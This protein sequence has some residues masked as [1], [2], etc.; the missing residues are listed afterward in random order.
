[1]KTKYLIIQP[2]SLDALF[3]ASH[4]LFNSDKYEVAVLTVEGDNKRLKEDSVLSE[5]LDIPFLDLDFEFIDNSYQSYW[6]T[7]KEVTPELALEFLY[8]FF[9]KDTMNELENLLTTAIQ[10]FQK[11]NKG[12]IV[13]SPWGCGEAFHMFVR[14]VIEN[15]V[16]YVEY[17]REFPHSYKKRIQNQ[18]EEQK[19]Q[20][21]FVR[22]VDTDEFHDLKFEVAKRVYKTQGGTLWFEQDYI[23][24]RLD[25]EIY[26]NTI[27]PF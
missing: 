10:K 21:N 11:K 5:M 17:Y 27:I 1:M 2:H 8:D 22:T 16:S 14:L 23:R 26:S 24:K 25:E 6:K 9:G 18:V 3:S 15:T 19:R 4:L 12:Y 7:N 13:L 20:H